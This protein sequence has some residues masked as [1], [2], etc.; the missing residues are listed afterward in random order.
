MTLIVFRKLHRV[1]VALDLIIVL[2]M[3]EV[4]SSEMEG[5]V[6]GRQRNKNY[7][8]WNGKLEFTW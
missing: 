5:D 4:M 6:T 1:K 8:C 7:L 2:R 3:N